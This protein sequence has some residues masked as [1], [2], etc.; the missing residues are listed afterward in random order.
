M[1]SLATIYRDLVFGGCFSYM[2]HELLPRWRHRICGPN[3]KRLDCREQRKRM[4]FVVNLVSAMTATILSSPFNY[5]RNMHY[6]TPPHCLPHSTFRI[7]T[8]LF[9]AAWTE[10]TYSKRW[11][12]LQVRLRL[13]W[14]TARVGC[15]MALGAFVYDLCSGRTHLHHSNVHSSHERAEHH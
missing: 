13:G 6:A 8:D 9:R 11:E 7:L 1:G 3:D 15:G 14:G 2:R 4:A 12:Y 5:V 10:G